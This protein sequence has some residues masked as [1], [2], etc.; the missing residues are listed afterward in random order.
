[1]SKEQRDGLFMDSSVFIIDEKKPGFPVRSRIIQIVAILIGSWSSVS[2][3]LEDFPAPVVILHVNLAILICAGIMF[4]L[5]LIPSYDVVKI[6]FGVLFYGLFFWSRFPKLQNGFYIMEN[7]AID[8]LSD[9]YEF[10]SEHFVA[11]YSRQTA[12]TTLLVIMIAL[13]IVTLL[14]VAVVRGHFANATSIVLF[15]PIAISFLFG[16]IPSEK[17]LITYIAAVLYLTRSGFP[18]HHA[19]NEEQKVIVHRIN[20]RA[21]VWLSLISILLFFLLKLFVSEEKY[22][23]ITQIKSLKADIQNTLYSINLENLT[24]GI[25]DFELPSAH[26]QAGGLDGGRLGKIGEVEYTESEQLRVTAPLEAL[27][28]G[29]YL[30]GYVGSVYTGDRWES[31]RDEEDELYKEFM[32]GIPAQRFS[33][34]NQVI[35]FIRAGYE[36]GFLRMPAPTR[37][38][39]DYE[40]ANRKYLY[41]PYYTDFDATAGI[42]YK[43]DLYAAPETKKETLNLVFYNVLSLS[44]NDF[45]EALLKGNLQI[46]PRLA[47]IKDYSEY[48][49]RY[50]Q[51]VNEAYTKLPEKGL[52]KLKQQCLEVLGEHPDYSDID[53]IAYVLDYLDRNTSYTLSPGRLPKNKDFVEYFLYEN[54]KGYCAHYA[55]AATLLLRGLDVPARYVEGYAVAS[56]DIINNAT[57]RSIINGSSYEGN[58]IVK[59]IEVSVKDYNAHAWTEVYLDSFGWIPVDF[60]PASSQEYS[61]ATGAE[62]NTTPA[63][64]TPEPVQDTP[65]PMIEEHSEDKQ[66]PNLPVPTLS[67][68]LSEDRIAQQ[69]KHDTL[70]LILFFVLSIGAATVAI[71]IFLHRRR[72]IRYTQN[73]NKRML[74]LYARIEKLLA[75]THSLGKR[76][77][78]LEDSEEYVKEHCTCVDTDR[79]AEFMETARKAR[80]GKGLIT[81]EEFR[82][83]KNFHNELYNRICSDMPAVKRLFIRIRLSF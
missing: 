34:V 7:I 48:E 61:Y 11:D 16:L 25:T 4:A 14:T 8:R 17:Y 33:P 50:R 57:F 1:M 36:A 2:I 59:D 28:G 79:F 53:K 58:R 43:Q 41:A 23:S 80:F 15:L 55:S 29:F 82:Q 39:I 19:V 73:R 63:T 78:R 54:K 62:D 66:E 37:M 71:V 22:D 83:A 76:G 13:P 12:D 9:Y 40:D 10:A 64:A 21:A 60:T 45:M 24:E 70:F 46:S 42:E 3:L 77:A 20:S 32:K 51:F 35:D 56:S 67:P 31:H 68:A 44:G 69:H 27:T 49:K 6:F 74:Y 5:C 18:S 75:A 81:P 30:K 72:R 26:T 52:G 47:Q 38:K 65:T